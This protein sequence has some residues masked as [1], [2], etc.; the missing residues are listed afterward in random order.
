[1][2]HL[3]QVAGLDHAIEIDSAGT[4]AYHVG[5]SPDERARE[6]ALRRG[7][8]LVGRARQFR[9]GDFS[10]FDYVV[11]MD[12]E[13]LE[14]LRDLAPDSAAAAK[15]SLLRQF[16]PKSPKNA[17][18]PDPYYGGARGFEDVLDVVFAGCQALLIEIRRR[19]EL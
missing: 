6:A 17:G 3:V 16:D 7:V 12:C 11:A 10:R 8:E 4:G 1:M 18:V 5:E 2:R 14:D 19:H 15:L 9:R 13:N